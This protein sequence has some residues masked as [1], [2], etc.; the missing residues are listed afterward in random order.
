METTI[1]VIVVI[2]TIVLSIAAPA[3]VMRLMRKDKRTIGMGMAILFAILLNGVVGHAQQ[4]GG[5]QRDCVGDYMRSMR[6]SADQAWTRAMSIYDQGYIYRTFNPI[7]VI[8]EGAIGIRY[9]AETQSAYW[10]MIGC[11]ALPLR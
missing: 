8:N 11:S 2:W 1:R 9:W 3:F 10:Q 7:A 4:G 5:T 6:M